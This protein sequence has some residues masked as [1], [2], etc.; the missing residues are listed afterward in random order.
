ME[1]NAWKWGRGIRDCWLHWFG[2]IVVFDEKEKKERD[3]LTVI[4]EAEVLV[5]KTLTVNA[6]FYTAAEAHLF[7]VP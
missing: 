1:N 5:V 4:A 6:H 3:K 7:K 2:N